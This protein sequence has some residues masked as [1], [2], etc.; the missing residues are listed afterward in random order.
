MTHSEMRKFLYPVPPPSAKPRVVCEC[1]CDCNRTAIRRVN[2][3]PMP[4]RFG[5]PVMHVLHPTPLR[6]CGQCTFLNDHE[7]Q[8]ID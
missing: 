1:P 2:R 3:I 4:H 8:D 5:H 6:V 7:R